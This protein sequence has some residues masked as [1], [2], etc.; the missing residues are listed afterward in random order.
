[1]RFYPLLNFLSFYKFNGRMF[2]AVLLMPLQYCGWDLLYWLPPDIRCPE[3]P[4]IFHSN[5]ISRQFSFL[6]PLS[7]LHKLRRGSICSR[8]VQVIAD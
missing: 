4:C 1:M 2:L 7:L 8:S 3:C 6:R 5:D